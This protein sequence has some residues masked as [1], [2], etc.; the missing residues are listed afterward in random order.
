MTYG[1][2]GNNGKKVVMTVMYEIILLFLMKQALTLS[3]SILKT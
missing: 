2:I 3:S 1:T